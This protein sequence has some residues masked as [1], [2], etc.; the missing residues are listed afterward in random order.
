M[1]LTP[2]QQQQVIAA[3]RQ[4]EGHTSGEIR[5]HIEATCPGADPVKRAIEVFKHLG[6]QQTKEQN[7]VLFYLAHD[8]RKFAV[9]GDKGID[10]KVPDDFWESTKDLMRQHFASNNY[11]TGLSVA[12][13]RAGQQLK[14]FFPRATDDTNELSDDI[15]FG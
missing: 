14:A 9:L 10:A 15:S 13:E 12:I 2:E 6:M 8:D 5:V 1:I 7:G 11:A 4:A 3:I